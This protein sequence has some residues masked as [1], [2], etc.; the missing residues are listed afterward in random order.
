LLGGAVALKLI[1]WPLVLWL[2]L[3]RKLRAALAAVA[4]FAL[5]NIIAAL[6][7]GPAP[8][9]HYYLEIGPRIARLHSTVSDNFS[10]WSAAPR[11]FIGLQSTL[12]AGVEAPPLVAAPALGRSLS[13]LLPTLLLCLG[14]NRACRAGS[15]DLACGYLVCTTILISPVA[16]ASYLTLALLPLIVALRRLSRAGWPLAETVL[17]LAVINVFLLAPYPL[18][19]FLHLLAL[20]PLPPHFPQPPFTVSFWTGS[21]TLLPAVALLTLM[22]LLRRLER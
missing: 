5:L 22:A 6:A 16:W 20:P 13:F 18:K 12:L 4:V 10:L 14:L 21:L 9:A 19:S 1:A 7:M 17:L 3:T 15:V 2:A 11:L 8:L